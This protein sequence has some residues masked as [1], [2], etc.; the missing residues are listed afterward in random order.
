M[1]RWQPIAENVSP[2][3]ELG[4][5]FQEVEEGRQLRMKFK[6]LP[7]SK[8]VCVGWESAFN[9]IYTE[10]N[11]TDFCNRFTCIEQLVHFWETQWE[12][13]DSFPRSWEKWPQGIMLPLSH[14]ILHPSPLPP[15]TCLHWWNINEHEGNWGLSLH[16][17]ACPIS[18]CFGNPS[19]R[20]RV[21]ASLEIHCAA[22]SEDQYVREA[23]S[24]HPATDCCHQ[25]T[26]AA[27]VIITNLPIHRIMSNQNGGWCRLLYYVVVCYA[28]KDHQYKGTQGKYPSKT[29]ETELQSR[30]LNTNELADEPT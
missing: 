15:V 5:D 7:S 1:N 14:L 18:Y 10:F 2:T 23:T 25:L 26:S 4:R 29:Q 9:K 28:P 24:D 30:E 3:L 21:Q 16:M 12:A 8:K 22:N 20:W 6:F 19:T 11:Q 13:K 27:L 17:G